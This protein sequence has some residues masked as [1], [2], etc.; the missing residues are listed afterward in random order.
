M[1]KNIKKNR[2]NIIALFAYSLTFIFFREV[3]YQAMGI[4]FG[5]LKEMI[6]ILP[7]VMIISGLISTWVPR[8]VILKH[9]GHGS[10]LKGKLISV[11]IGSISAG[12]IYAAFPFAQTLLIK[13]ASITNVVII[14]SSW[15][16]MKIPMLIV[17]GK[18]LGLN[19]VMARYIFTL[20]GII[21]MANLLNLWIKPKDIPATKNQMNPQVEII[22]EHLPGYNCSSCGYDSCE[23]YAQSI[24]KGSSFNNQCH[25]LDESSVSKI[26]ESLIKI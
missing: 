22:K 13:G 17:E 6:E 3:F 18:F 23:A 26:K 14:I 5:Y 1:M 19:F 20:P 11:L 10:G 16:V 15:A 8:S 9:F 4:S 2:I 12:P 25:V 21:V 24:V 7:A